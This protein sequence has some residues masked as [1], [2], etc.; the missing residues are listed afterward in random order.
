MSDM[1]LNE[2]MAALLLAERI[3]RGESFNEGTVIK[4]PGKDGLEIKATPA[5]LEAAAK[6][7]LERH[8]YGYEGG[9]ADEVKPREPKAEAKT[10]EKKPPKDKKA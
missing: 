1:T 2:R 8:Q 5:I 10:D 9:A 4:L 7:A 3:A 6:T